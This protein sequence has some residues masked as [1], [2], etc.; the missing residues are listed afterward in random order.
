MSRRPFEV[1]KH[2]LERDDVVGIIL[3]LVLHLH[4]GAGK[5]HAPGGNAGGGGGL[6]FADEIVGDR[7]VDSQMDFRI[8]QTL[9][10]YVFRR[11]Q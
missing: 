4:V 6:G 8:D 3:E 1:W 7:P 9:E 10:E 5:L 2:V 11:R